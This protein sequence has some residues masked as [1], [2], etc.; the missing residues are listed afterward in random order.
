MTRQRRA[1]VIG[2]SMGG[3]FAAQLLVRRGW[4]VDVFERI[5]SELA[6][7][8][9]GIVTHPELFDVLDKCGIDSSTAKVGVSVEG[10]RVFGRDG[11]L[12]GEQSYPQILTSW[13]MLYALLKATLPSGCYHYGTN[14][15][16]VSQ[17][18]ATVKAH[19]DDGEVVEGDLL[20]GADGIFSTVRT[21]FLPEANPNYVG[22]IAW[23]GLVDEALLSEATR[24]DLCNH[25]SFSLPKGEQM[26]GYPVAGVDEST[27]VGSRRFNFVWYRPAAHDGDLREILTDTDGVEHALSIPPHKIRPLVID[28]MRHAAREL[29]SP[30]FAEVVSK[31][32]QPFIQAIQDLETPQ[33]AI[34]GNIALIGDAAF[35]ARPHVGMGVTKA[36]GDA[37]AL[38]EALDAHRD[39]PSALSAFQ[40]S[41]LAYG[42]AVIRRARHLGAYMQAQLLTEEEKQ[43][44]EQHRHP[45]AIMTETA[46]SAGIA[47]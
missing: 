4:K 5:N 14:L 33:M 10:R 2:G 44:A 9:A 28:S 31:T 18:G 37:L 15:L 1:L 35:V 8:G 20:I 34:G 25:F 26:L 38:A 11:M 39:I 12:I 24:E 47:A 43:M 22:Y 30:Q 21:Q 13:G 32:Q 23:R 42:A 19:F 40:N 7:R 46:T 16:K 3:L 29:L 17:D 6:G 41:R 45:Q 27:A 36:A